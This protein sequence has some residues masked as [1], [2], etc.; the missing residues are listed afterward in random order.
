VIIQARYNGPPD[1]GNGGYSA[2]LTASHAPDRA[3]GIEVTLR[4]PPPL[5]TELTVRTEDRIRVYAGTELIA[6]ATHRAVD[7]SDVVPGVDLTEAVAVSK[8]YRGFVAHPFPTC[9]GC[10]PARPEADGLRLFPGR[11]PDG[12]MAAPFTVPDDVSEVLMWAALDCPGGWAVPSA[13]RDYV[14]GRIAARVDAL[15]EPGAECVVVAR[16][17]GE[18]GRKAY[19]LTTVYSPAGDV[20]AT[21]RATWIAI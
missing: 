1:S 15:P 9:F 10:G 8:S 14:L 6:E 3:G 12:R 21:A 4:R 13:A 5:D 11:L 20:L 16:M 19:A 7:A 2:G 17:T 18:E